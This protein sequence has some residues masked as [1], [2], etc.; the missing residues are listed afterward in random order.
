VPAIVYGA[1]K[2]PVPVTVVSNVLKKQLENEAFLSHILTLRID[3]STPEQ[4]VVKDLQRH[5]ASSQV[6]HLDLMRVSATHKLTMT[7]PIHF[8]NEDSSP[9]RK[10]GGTISHH[11]I[12]ITVSCLPKDL[13]EYIA[14]DVGALELD[15]AIHLSQIT[16][17]EGVEFDDLTEDNDPAIVAVAIQ[18][19]AEEEEVEAEE[20][21]EGIAAVASA[22]ADESE[23]EEKPGEED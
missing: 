14:V 1:G 19:V 17:P 20:G 11:S 3:G 12:E 16:V 13:P 23:G 15:D 5:P 8:E 4:V 2:D 9:G 18:H 22:A 10:A 7:I 6:V 21:I